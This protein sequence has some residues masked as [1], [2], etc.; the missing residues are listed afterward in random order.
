MHRYPRRHVS[1]V[2]VMTAVVGLGPTA[3][4][5]AGSVPLPAART[6]GPVV[7]GLSVHA[8]TPRGGTELVITGT[9]LGKPTSVRFGGVAATDVTRR[10]DGSISAV[11]PAHAS[12]TVHVRVT[13]ASRQSAPNAASRYIYVVPSHGGDLTWSAPRT[14]PANS[15]G[16]G[17][18]DC[19][20]VTFCVATDGYGNVAYF[21]GSSW[22]AHH[23]ID[24]TAV[25]ELSCPTSTFCMAVDSKGR[26]LH[27]D[28]T[29]WSKPAPLFANGSVTLSCGAATS[30]LAMPGEG[31]YRYYDGSSWSAQQAVPDVPAGEQTAGFSCAPARCVVGTTSTV[32]S[33]A[34]LLAFDGSA[35]SDL[36]EYDVRGGDY[37][38]FAGVSK[39]SCPTDQF[40]AIFDSTDQVSFLNGSTVSHTRTISG[41]GLS[42]PRTI[43]CS[44]STLCMLVNEDDDAAYAVVFAGH[45]W[46]GVPGQRLSDSEWAVT[47]AGPTLCVVSD[48]DLTRVYRGGA[49]STGDLVFP[50]VGLQSISCVTRTFCLTADDN[51]SVATFDGKKFSSARQVVH[52]SE[53]DT[54]VSCA[55][56]SWCAVA[57][58]T[59][60]ALY[61]GSRW[62]AG[63][64]IDRYRITGIACGSN[65]ECV[66]V[67]D[68][69]RVVQS[70]GSHW[71]KPVTKDAHDHFISVSC[72]GSLCAAIDSEGY[73]LVRRDGH[74]SGRHAVYNDG[75]YTQ[76]Y[77]NVSC[78]SEHL[79][80]IV[81]LDGTTAKYDGHK[82]HRP[83]GV[84]IDSNLATYVTCASGRFC[85]VGETARHS[86]NYAFDGSTWSNPHTF[87]FPK[88]TQIG[89]LS[90]VS[91]TWCLEQPGYAVN[92]YSV[93]TR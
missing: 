72:S 37:D 31:E 60:A 68:R 9:G 36:G 8:G 90:C 59:R 15:G 6:A 2:V 16:L 10:G 22:G 42:S 20:T 18:V 65:H 66:A 67:D 79:C 40:C 5:A 93:G 89:A 3:V 46:H 84:S 4:S 86:R 77:A 74:W 85:L 55:T 76:V 28:G 44:S 14:A 80:M 91:S 52:S 25:Y 92:D 75:A 83:V 34:H 12:G 47:C 39:V 78:G 41:D 56:R 43:S 88:R 21:D 38:D 51:G 45:G 57:S 71:G 62:R 17:A 58:G 63:Q 35:W 49:L 19:P 24:G 81:N 32:T 61:D 70:H 54:D 87:G 23:R 7:T 27:Y 50:A 33:A 26:T 82:W 1:A 73:A 53:Y 64:K 30:C 29:T 48:G 11:T 13:T 69:G